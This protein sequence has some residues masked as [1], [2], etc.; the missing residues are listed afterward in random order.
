VIAPNDNLVRVLTPGSSYASG[1]RG[2]Q[3]V[4]FLCYNATIPPIAHG[5]TR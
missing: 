5:R 3:A 1:L 4:D 2:K